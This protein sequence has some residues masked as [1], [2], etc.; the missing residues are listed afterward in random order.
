M[1]KIFG[2]AN[3]VSDRVIVKQQIRGIFILLSK[4]I[5]FGL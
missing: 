3:P 1:I 5:R 4:P 2:S